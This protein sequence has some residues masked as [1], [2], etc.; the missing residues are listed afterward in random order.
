MLGYNVRIMIAIK[1]P[2]PRLQNIERTLLIHIIV[3]VS[4]DVD[5]VAV[6]NDGCRKKIVM[7]E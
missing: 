2:N 4:N 5:A 1:Q 3:V 7:S 6:T